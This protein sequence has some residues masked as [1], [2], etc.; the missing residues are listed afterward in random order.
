M[1]RIEQKSASHS[2]NFPEARSFTFC[3]LNKTHELNS[4]V[5]CASFH[6]CLKACASVC[7]CGSG[8]GLPP[9]IGYRLHMP[10]P[11]SPVECRG[12]LVHGRFAVCL[13]A[14]RPCVS[15]LHS[16]ECSTPM[17]HEAY[18]YTSIANAYTRSRANT[19]RP[20]F[21]TCVHLVF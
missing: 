16:Q 5:V 18:T 6:R 9:A 8:E 2:L 7:D 21:V 12:A 11:W 4:H 15:K 14:W 20:H 3:I 19:Q 10:V 13:G 17:G 1:I